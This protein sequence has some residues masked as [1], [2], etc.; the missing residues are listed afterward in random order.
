MCERAS[1]ACSSRSKAWH[2][3]P[4]S[5]LCIV[6]SDLKSVARP[7]PAGG[8]SWGSASPRRQP[9][10]QTQHKTHRHTQNPRHHC[11]MHSQLMKLTSRGAPLA[12]PVPLRSLPP[13]AQRDPAWHDGARRDTHPLS[14]KLTAARGG[15][16]CCSEDTTCHTATQPAPLPQPVRTSKN[17]AAANSTLPAPPQAAVVSH[18]RAG[19][20]RA[21]AGH[22]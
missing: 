14:S 7:D 9:G 5:C 2:A 6:F 20:G 8:A 11:F 22:C 19:Q 1:P 21:R 10:A 16:A 13:Q 17:A 3:P 12:P 15:R 4:N 18:W